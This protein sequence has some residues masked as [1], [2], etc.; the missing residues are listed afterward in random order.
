[1][2][3]KLDYN[4]LYYFRYM[5]K[6]YGKLEV[7]DRTPLIMVLDVRKD[8]V[9]ALNFHWLPRKDKL[10]L[11]DSIREI[12]TKTHMVSKRRERMRLTY[13]LLKKPKYRVGLQAIRMYYV[14][15][16]SQLKDIP[17]K[18]WDISMGISQLRARKVYKEKGYKE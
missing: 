6:G 3:T 11:F 8:N 10:E 18:Q 14:N 2:I 4:K 12:M 16:I 17:E 9:L 5:P 13:Q 7:Y 15:G 1:M